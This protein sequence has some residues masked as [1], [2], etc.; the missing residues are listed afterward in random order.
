MNIKTGA[1]QVFV[2]MVEVGG[3]AIVF[4]HL[5]VHAGLGKQGIRPKTYPFRVFGSI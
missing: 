3:T 1:G 4:T 2:H 5:R